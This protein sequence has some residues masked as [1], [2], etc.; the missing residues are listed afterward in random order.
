MAVVTLLTDFGSRDHFAAAMKGVMLGIDPGLTL[1][2]VTHD[3]PRG[4]VRA[5]AF[6]LAQ[7]CFLF[8]P[9]TVHLAVVDPG[10]GGGRKALAVAAGGHRFV[11]PDNG[12]LTPVFES[13]ADFEAH[14]IAPGRAGRYFRQ[15]VSATFHGRDVFAP[16]AAW[17]CRGVPL[18]QLGPPLRDPVQL[19]SPQALPARDG[20]G[21]FIQGA[22]LAV[23]RFGNLVTNLRPSDVAT[24]CEIEVGGRV[25]RALRQTYAEG[26]PGEVFAV[27]G[28]AGYVE[29]VMRDGSAAE[30][31]QLTAGAPVRCNLS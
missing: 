31:L 8:P 10:V 22:V 7:C 15:P 21:A 28:S 20:R 13:C 14:E 27:Q 18:E 1:V 19:P 16:V 11:A 23:D 6:T 2:D 17:L 30:A 9:G 25:I 5:G 12:I 29:I 3:I 24:P 26:A 4:D